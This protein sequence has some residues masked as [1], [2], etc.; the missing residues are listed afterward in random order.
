MDLLA[1]GLPGVALEGESAGV[2][3]HSLARWPLR[4]QV[5]HTCRNR[6]EPGNTH[7]PLFHD[8][9]MR[10]SVSGLDT[11][12]KTWGVVDETPAEGCHGYSDAS[13][14]WASMWSGSRQS[15]HDLFVP[16]RRD[17]TVAACR[18][19]FNSCQG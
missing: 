3:S 1:A 11:R 18:L 13:A 6:Q 10:S 8:E 9:Q 4:L 5:A 17:M 2:S 7:L 16:D 19:A 14:H 15:L 12:L